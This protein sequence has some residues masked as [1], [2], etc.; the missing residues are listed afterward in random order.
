MELQVGVKIFLK[1]KEG[2][3]LVLKRNQE[4][5]KDV[6]NIWDIPGGRINPGSTLIEN[7]KREVKEETNLGI[8]GEPKLIFAQDIMT[9]NG[10][11]VVRLTYVG[12]SIGEFVLDNSENIDYK[13][14]NLDELKKFE[15]LCEFAG[16]IL[17]K[18]TQLL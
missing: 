16:A 12:D 13:W 11:H 7:L 1:N 10:K 4:K 15:G 6:K 9:K 3:I 18:N 14:L 8:L 5:Y 17:E 2:K